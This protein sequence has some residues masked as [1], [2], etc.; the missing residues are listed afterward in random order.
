MIQ[1]KICMLGAP[2]VGKT[3]LVRRFVESIFQESYQTTVGVKIDKKNLSVK[4]QDLSLILWD[5]HG[6]S[7]F[8]RVNKAYLRGMAGY[9]LVVDSTRPETLETALLLKAL[10]EEDTTVPFVLILNKSDLKS[11]LDSE[12]LSRID[13][14]LVFNTS[15]KTG[16]KVEEAFEALAKSLIS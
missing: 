8:Q 7:K 4:G 13:T 6:D 3:S 9:L 5:L 10:A 16:E 11:K 2:S 1:K 14:D 12:A 15:A